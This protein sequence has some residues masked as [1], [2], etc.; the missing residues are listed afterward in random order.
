MYNRM[1]VLIP[2]IMLVL[3]MPVALSQ[4]SST[5]EPVWFYPMPAN[6]VAV[7]DDG[8]VVAVASDGVYVY[9]Q[10]GNL[11]WHWPADSS[12]IVTSIDMTSDG[13]IIV[14]A[15]YNLSDDTFRIVF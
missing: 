15:V 8:T 13:N 14:A 5:I 4:P 11:L 6:D 12:I 2:L 10:E 9:N 3:T 7:S 1:L